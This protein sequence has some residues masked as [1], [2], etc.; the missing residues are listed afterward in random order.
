MSDVARVST[1]PRIGRRR[2]EILAARRKRVVATAAL[3]VTVGLGLWI[4][5]LSPVLHIRQIRVLGARHTGKR[6]VAVATELK[7]D[8]NLLLISTDE[9]AERVRKLPWVLDA[10]V[11]R[12]LP[13][14]V[15][16]R[17][18]E[19]KPALVLSG[20]G[21]KWTLDRTGRV[22]ERG[23]AA[24]N[25]PVV[26]GF[27]V[28]SVEPGMELGLPEVRAVLR[29]YRYLPRT[30]RTRVEGVFAPTE[31]RLSFSLADG[32]LIRYGAAERLRAKNEVLLALM[33]R[34]KGEGATVA[35]LDVRVPTSPAV[36]PRVG[37]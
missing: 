21:T 18:V 11:A 22:L 17:I 12:S 31:E 29:A 20:T 10:A 6:A 37:A 4:A 19:R 36:G 2:A 7:S 26:A 25:L 27:D 5:L 35:Y 33:G 34:L 8:D 24:K 14:T 30:L 28:P 16:V 15:R 3:I 13:G 23:V 32:T 1:D 9:I